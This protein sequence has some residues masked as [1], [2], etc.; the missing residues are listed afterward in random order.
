MARLI[1]VARAAGVSR[2]TASNVFNNPGIVRPELRRR[3]E[4]AALELGYGGPDPKG[5]LLRAGKVNAIGVMPPSEWG[6]AESLANPVF[7]LFLRGVGE[8]CDERGANLVLLSGQADKGSLRTAV[9]DGFIFGRGEHLE[10]VEPA[11]LRRLPFTVVDFD[12]GPGM[13]SVRVDARAGAY[14][15]ARHLLDLGHRRFGIISFLRSTGPARLHPAGQARGPEAAGIPTDQEKYLGYAD[16]LAEAGIDI[17]DVPMVQAEPRDPDAARMILDAAPEAT[18]I[19]SMAVM[20]GIE[21]L[22]EARTRGLV[23]PRDLSVV[24]DSENAPA[25]QSTPPL[26]TVDGMGIEKGRAAARMVLASGPPRHEI[27]RPRLILRASTGPAPR[28]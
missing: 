24:A 11:Q 13:S 14:L 23:V 7:A 21:V 5:R 8:T 4:A 15:A 9:V 26:T 25:A 27:L 28:R 19:L 20:Q 12:P 3:V 2:S 10:Q 6:I 18:A 17:A 22:A 16:A 1:D